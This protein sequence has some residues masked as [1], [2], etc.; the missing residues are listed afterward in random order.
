MLLQV[1]FLWYFFPVETIQTI[2]DLSGTAGVRTVDESSVSSTTWVLVKIA[3]VGE[4]SKKSVVSSVSTIFK[5]V[6]SRELLSGF[7][8]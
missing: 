4:L 7:L 2:V 3:V 6:L 5:D 1:D 8:L